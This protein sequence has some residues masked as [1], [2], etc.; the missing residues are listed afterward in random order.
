MVAKA[1]SLVSCSTGGR[2]TARF[3]RA[4]AVIRNLKRK[5]PA[6]TRARTPSGSTENSAVSAPPRSPSPYRV[7]LFHGKALQ[8]LQHAGLPPLLHLLHAPLPL[9]EQLHDGVGGVHVFIVRSEERL[10]LWREWLC[11][12]GMAFETSFTFYLSCFHPL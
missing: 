9:Q 7:V 1:T 5:S 2:P 3:L 10:Q 4:M 11:F 6:V 8:S 12:C